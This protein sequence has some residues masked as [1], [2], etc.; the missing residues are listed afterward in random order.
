M[1]RPHPDPVRN[2]GSETLVAGDIIRT[3][4]VSGRRAALA[5]D[6]LVLSFAEEILLIIRQS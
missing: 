4:N 6:S 2:H 1:D 5:A 3:I